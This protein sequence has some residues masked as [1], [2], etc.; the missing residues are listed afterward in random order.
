MN[1]ALWSRVFKIALNF[2]PCIW[3]SGGRITHLS[4]DFT[5]LRIRLPLSWRTRNRVGTIYG[6]SMYSSTDP[7]FMLML[8][9]ILGR[10]FVVWDKAGNIRFKRPAQE[11][12]YVEFRITPEML[13]AVRET[14]ARAKEG[15]FTWTIELR[16]A[17]GVV[18][19]EIEK[20]IYVAQKSFYREKLAS[21]SRL[22]EKTE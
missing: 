6:G 17:S 18:H 1:R 16:S 21:R 19:A 3:S 9:E 4:E 5:L 13:A 12:L 20:T 10:E 15:S 22:T 7:F 8:M 11:T 14:V 2:W